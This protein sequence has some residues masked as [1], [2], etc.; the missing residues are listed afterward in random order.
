[1]VHRQDGR[2]VQ[3][4]EPEAR[5][6]DR[7]NSPDFPLRGCGAWSRVSQ[8]SF[9]RIHIEGNKAPL[10]HAIARIAVDGGWQSQSGQHR[11]AP[12]MV[13]IPNE[14]RDNPLGRSLLQ[15]LHEAAGVLGRLGLDQQV[16]VLRHQDPADQQEGHLREELAQD[17]H[18]YQQTPSQ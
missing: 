11:A 14:R 13:A 3:I 1:M 7:E 9:F 15:L 10:A 2:I 17:V 4:I 16:K 18:K 8:A 6:P 5:G 12:E